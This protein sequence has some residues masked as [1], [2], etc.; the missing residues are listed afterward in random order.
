MLFWASPRIHS[1]G[2]ATP[3]LSQQLSSG[4]TCWLAPQLT[5]A[6]PGRAQGSGRQLR[7][8]GPHPPP[9]S[10]FSMSCPVQFPG[11]PF[12]T[13]PP[14]SIC[15]PL[16]HHCH[17]RRLCDCGHHSAMG[18]EFALWERQNREIDRQT[19]RQTSDTQEKGRERNKWAFSSFHVSMRHFPALRQKEGFFSSATQE[20]KS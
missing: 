13:S 4:L 11:A 7:S 18:P 12:P 17:T 8:K 14:L 9:S 1:P 5:Q 16:L 2:W 3:L 10:A 19:D 6:A 15:P 20:R